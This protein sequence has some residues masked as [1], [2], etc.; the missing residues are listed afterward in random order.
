MKLSESP[1]VCFRL[2]PAAL[3]SGWCCVTRRSRCWSRK[4]SVQEDRTPRQRFLPQSDPVVSLLFTDQPRHRGLLPYPV[5][6]GNAG[7][8][9]AGRPRPQPAARG[10]AGPAER[11]LLPGRTLTNTHFTFPLDYITGSWEEMVWV[12]KEICPHHCKQINNHDET[13]KG[14]TEVKQL[15]LPCSFRA[16]QFS[17][18]GFT[19][20]FY[21][22]C[23]VKPVPVVDVAKYISMIS[24]LYANYLISKTG[25]V[26][27]HRLVTKMSWCRCQHSPKE[28]KKVTSLVKSPFGQLKSPRGSGNSRLRWQHGSDFP[29]WPLAYATLRRYSKAVPLPVPK[30]KLTAPFCNFWW[31]LNDRLKF[32]SWSWNMYVMYTCAHIYIFIHKMYFP[33]W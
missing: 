6:L 21:W 5:Q 4:H 25:G 23:G 26:L 19:L 2:N 11:P 27:S 14:E 8:S 12:E 18:R 10:P 13:V 24:S 28:Q 9:A 30:I 33:M 17:Y 22:N 32:R 3:A 16:F 31:H 15:R 29:L 1:T 20:G 7:E